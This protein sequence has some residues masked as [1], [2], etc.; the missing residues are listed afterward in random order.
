MFKKAV[1]LLQDIQF[2]VDL[3][4]YLNYPNQYMT[5]YPANIIHH[6]SHGTRAAGQPEKMKLE[7]IT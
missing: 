7:S 3:F 2:L 1:E 5:S 6:H 4:V